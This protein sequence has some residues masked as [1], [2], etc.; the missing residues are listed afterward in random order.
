MS[1]MDQLEKTNK[2]EESKTKEEK[3]EDNDPDSI[4]NLEKLHKEQ[5]AIVENIYVA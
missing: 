4:R 5:L 1:K 3:E 2:K